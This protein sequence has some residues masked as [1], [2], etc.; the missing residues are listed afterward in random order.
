MSGNV[1]RW[2]NAF[3]DRIEEE[4]GRHGLAYPWW[5][6]VA[7]VAGQVG[8]AIVAVAQRGAVLPP[9]PVALAVVLVAAPYVLQFVR[10]WVPWWLR[11]LF[12]L[13]G[14]AWLL[15]TPGGVDPQMDVTVGVIAIM[16]AEVTATDGA[17]VG[18]GVTAV[19]IVVFMVSDL[20]AGTGLHTI[21]IMFGLVVGAMLRT[22]MRAVVA[23]RDAR[24]GESERATLAERQRIA[25]EIHD[26]VGHSLSVT[27][28]HVTGAR[29]AL[30]E[31]DDVPEAIDA[32]TDAERI[33]RQAMTDIRRT[34]HVLATEPE[35]TAPLPSA[36]DV[37][38]LV[39]D[40]RAAGLTVDY[41]VVGD[42]EA[43]SPAAGLGVYRIAQE[44][45]ANVAKHAPQERVDLTL[46]VGVDRLRLRVRNRRPDPHEPPGTDGS[47]LTGMASRAQQLGGA[48]E[49]GPD[50]DH[51]QVDLVVPVRSADHDT[52]KPEP[53]CRV[54]RMLP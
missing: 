51:W 48:C 52:Q 45:L 34:V 35:G 46:D 37:D 7:S 18:I 6:P 25:R 43:L 53:D 14:T 16:N 21:E 27:L 28:L 13:S 47:G 24:A 4:G 10:P 12:V 44:S 19:S 11:S 32:L 3:A 31:D 5:I 49:A 30:S 22:Q 36:G 40:V 41:R 2:A 20:N 38:A 33:G 50:G 42:R 8:C 26:L 29:R 9:E 39:D 1:A 17:K 15:T 23:E 54:R